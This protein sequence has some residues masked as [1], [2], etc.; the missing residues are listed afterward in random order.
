[1]IEASDPM[2]MGPSQ[3]KNTESQLIKFMLN[4]KL[5]AQTIITDH[6]ESARNLEKFKL[7]TESRE[8][9]KGLVMS[10]FAAA[11]GNHLGLKSKFMVE[12]FLNKYPPEHT[13]KIVVLQCRGAD[14]LRDIL[15]Q[16]ID[17]QSVNLAME[18]HTYGK[19]MVADTEASRPGKYIDLVYKYVLSR[20][21][22]V[23]RL[24]FSPFCCLLYDKPRL[25][26]SK[27]PQQNKKPY[28]SR[29]KKTA[30]LKKD[31]D[32]EQADMDPRKLSLKIMQ[33]VEQTVEIKLK[34]LQTKSVLSAKASIVMNAD[35]M[36]IR[37]L[38]AP[39]KKDTFFEQ[40][41]IF[42][43]ITDLTKY[44]NNKNV[45]LS[46]TGGRSLRADALTFFYDVNLLPL[47]TI[48]KDEAQV[49]SS[50][51]ILP[52]I[53]VAADFDLRATV[54]DIFVEKIVEH[55]NWKLVKVPMH[56]EFFSE[57]ISN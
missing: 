43:N 29:L 19:S 49:D 46:L 34:G 23:D 52:L 16:E 39:I 47:T 12:G 15:L 18:V 4:S 22:L 45:H 3:P 36:K 26:S 35:T 48:T 53:V 40:F 32:N 14:Q 57:S 41:Q 24:R 20:L 28:M 8:K 1:M 31:D 9:L 56:K 55:G 27:R 51:K 13:S 5:L 21:K 44:I 38:L 54:L 25:Q 30:D 2:I 6:R 7:Y 33:N 11:A 37:E 42:H 50:S 17:W 10:A